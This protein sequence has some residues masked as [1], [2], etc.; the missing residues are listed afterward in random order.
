MEIE[1]IYRSYKMFDLASRKPDFQ[2]SCSLD[3][4]QPWNLL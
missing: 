3:A 4:G 2:P 1:K